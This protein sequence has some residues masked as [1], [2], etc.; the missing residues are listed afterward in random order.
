VPAE[1]FCPPA[2]RCGFVSCSLTAPPAAGIAPVLLH[3]CQAKLAKSGEAPA[4]P[5]RAATCSVGLAQHGGD[6]FQLVT[7]GCGK[8]KC[9][10]PGQAG[11]VEAGTKHH[12]QTWV[13]E[14]HSRKNS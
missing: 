3:L 11:A 14:R 5:P 1:G 12:P 7:T 8:V 4:E 2:L 6:S 9:P 10:Q 13:M